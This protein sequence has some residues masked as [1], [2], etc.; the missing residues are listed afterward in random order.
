MTTRKKTARKGQGANIDAAGEPKVDQAE[1]NKLSFYDQRILLRKLKKSGS[2]GD[3]DLDF[4]DWIIGGANFYS[5]LWPC[6]FGVGNDTVRITV[7]FN[8]ELYNGTMLTSPENE[9]LLQGIKVLLAVQ[10]HPRFNGN[11][12]RSGTVEATEFRYGMQFVDHLLMNGE[13]LQLASTGFNLIRSIDLFDYMVK[14][15]G[16]PVSTCLY[17]YPTKLS[18][19]LS[20]VAQ[21]VSDSQIELALRS[22]EGLMELPSSEDRVLVLT[23]DE[24]IRARAY[25]VLNKLFSRQFGLVKYNSTSF[26][27]ALYVNTLAGRDLTPKTF[28]ELNEGESWRSEYPAV[29]VR[30]ESKRPPSKRA[31]T[32]HLKVIL[33]LRLVQELVPGL[34]FNPD[35]LKDINLEVISKRAVYQP[36]GRYR[37]VPG[38][39]VFGLIHDAYEYI[40]SVKDR[41][42]D[43]VIELAVK[44][45]LDYQ[46]E[47]LNLNSNDALSVSNMLALSG[48]N[49]SHWLNPFSRQDDECYTFL[50]EGKS[51]F[52]AYT[53]LMGAYLSII[54]ALTA[55]RQTE[56]LTLSAETCLVPNSNPYLAANFDTEYDI[57]FM[58]AKTGNRRD[59]EFLTV[60]IPSLVARLLWDLK[61]LH[62]RFV[63]SGLVP[64]S[65]PLLCYV[66]PMDLSVTPMSPTT[67]NW[68]IS[69]FSDYSQAPT[70]VID[71]KI[72]R[73]YV[74]Q[75]QLRRFFATAFF[76]CAGFKDLDALRAFLGHSDIQHLYSY[77]LEVT[78]GSML[79]SVQA[80]TLTEAVLTGNSSIEN[81]NIIKKYLCEINGFH[82]LSVRTLPSLRAVL[83]RAAMADSEVDDDAIPKLLEQDVYSDLNYLL[84]VKLI[85]LQPEFVRV[86]RSDGVQQDVHLVV[87]I[88]I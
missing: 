38:E 7:D 70:V 39:V 82:D 60:P 12:R 22:F 1:F 57:G 44:N 75:H 11:K 20:C 56:L 66:S 24:L 30:N 15:T 81:I 5:T 85:D 42:V 16:N 63:A 40:L 3:K 41:V 47:H 48:S 33:R 13:R 37:S 86:E 53:V 36:V 28:I 68:C 4:P 27:K 17:D 61:C 78:P 35:V 21:E 10:V 65:A 50:R 45:V 73:F 59:K 29:P 6:C 49:F 9:T 88:N 55:R 69:Q 43:N 79:Q 52:D 71:G 26:L 34:K 77:I 2:F 23:D 18:S 46:F 31:V 74:R 32:R 51:L 62:Q 80:Q 19:F 76:S 58:A 83:N 54:G 84:S 87:R 72:H 8:I 67:Y 14:K 64:A 25:I